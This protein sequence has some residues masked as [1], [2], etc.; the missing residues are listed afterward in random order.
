MYFI[1]HLLQLFGTYNVWKAEYFCQLR[2]VN[3]YILLCADL[4]CLIPK[5]KL[6]SFFHTSP[7]SA[8]QEVIATCWPNLLHEDD[9][10]FEEEEFHTFIRLVGF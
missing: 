5:R 2:C 10:G 7:K 9:K 1:V 6:N 4:Q 8:L 3:F